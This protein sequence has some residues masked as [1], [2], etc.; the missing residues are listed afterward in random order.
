MKLLAFIMAQSVDVTPDLSG[1][2]GSDRVQSLINIAA[3]VAL[4]MALAGIII[5]GG[6]WGIG[7]LSSNH[8][9]A[10]VGKRATLYSVL[11]GLIVGAGPLLVNW[12]FNF[13]RGG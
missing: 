2:P 6:L 3:G 5:G 1:I 12:A 7:S 9:A 13:G 11:G 8:H 4:F 10:T